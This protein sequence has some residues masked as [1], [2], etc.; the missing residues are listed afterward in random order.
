MFPDGVLLPF[1]VF[2]GGVGVIVL[3]FRKIKPDIKFEKGL[4]T[5]EDF[6]FG[7]EEDKKSKPDG[8]SI[9]GL[10]GFLVLWSFIPDVAGILN[11]FFTFRN[12]LLYAFLVVL[13]VVPLGMVAV[14][15]IRSLL[16]LPYAV[17]QH[18]LSKEVKERDEVV[19]RSISA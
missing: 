9:G 4:L 7:V 1:V 10:R 15:C 13:V 6:E 11:V 2:I 12:A 14:M 17:F 19:R 18:T 5:I 16:V 8:M 3:I